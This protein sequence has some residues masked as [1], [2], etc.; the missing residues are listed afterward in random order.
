MLLICFVFPVLASAQCPDRDSLNKR[1]NFYSTD[2]L[3]VGT[4]AQFKELKQYEKQLENCVLRGDSTHALLLQRIGILYAKQAKCLQA[5]TYLHLSN[6]LVKDNIRKRSVNPDFFIKNYYNL[7]RIYDS[8]G[9]S[10]ESTAALDSCITVYNNLKTKLQR[11]TYV[12]Y[13]L[14][15]MELKTED[16]YNVGDYNK[17][18]NYASKGEKY[19]ADY[20]NNRADS[21]HYFTTFLSWKFNALLITQKYTQAEALLQNKADACKKYGSLQSLGSIYDFLGQVEI[22][23]NNSLKAKNYFMQSIKY[24]WNFND[25]IGCMQTYLNLG[26]HIYDRSYKNP[27]LALASY[28]QGLALFTGSSKSLQEGYRME[29]LNLLANMANIYVQYKQYD[30]ALY[31]YQLAFDQITP[32]LQAENVPDIPLERVTK[33]EYLTSLLLDQ[34]DAYYKLYRESKNKAAVEKAINLYRTTDKLLDRIKNEQ[35]DVA[36]KLFWRR[37]NHRLYEHAIEACY[38]IGGKAGEAFY[39]FEKSRAALLNDQLTEQQFLG[40]QDMFLQAQLQ[41]KIFKLQQQLKTSIVSLERS[42]RM[43]DEL[44]QYKEKLDRFIQHNKKGN[45]Y[46]FQSFFD[47][48]SITIANVQKTILKDHKALVELFEGDSAVYVLAITRKSAWLKRINKADYDS[49]LQHYFNYVSD[50]SLSNR[51]TAA[52]YNTALH[53]YKLLFPDQALPAGRI[54]VSPDGRYIPFE[55]LITSTSKKPV[56]FVNDYAVSYTYSAR[57]LLILNKYKR[58]QGAGTQT[59]LGIAP[60]TY[61]YDKVLTDLQQSDQSV[62]TVQTYFMDAD[63]FTYG[64]ATKEKFLKN[65]PKY[66]IVYLSTHASDSGSTGEPVIYFA[67]GP[68]SLSEFVV[69]E[70]PATQLV[71][72]SACKTGLGQVFRGEGVY[73]FSRSF[74]SVGIPASVNNLWSVQESAANELTELFCRYIADGE[75]TDV[76]L[77]MAKKKMIQAGKNGRDLPYYW[78]A[79]IL[80][81]TTDVIVPKTSR[82]NMTVMLS[83]LALLLTG[84]TLLAS[85]V[86]RV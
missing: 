11:R 34:A 80:S 57:Y 58:K 15:M 72:A 55:A 14:R 19:I 52:H 66:K 24:A 37:D 12:R 81:G 25:T 17:C 1:L 63:I 78:A 40:D 4:P 76:A 77:Q 85:R 68:L 42:N 32:G 20:D 51:N 9:K 39:F 13:V 48:A 46:R 7:F 8:L 50:Y 49:T 74:A 29:A 82:W 22:Y 62:R 18:S 28:R 33:I 71:I 21:M 75:P 70:R 3:A 43:Q 61:K 44:D 31:Y 65:A 35:Q 41:S 73:N 10:N 54:I 36:S 45:N 64:E 47:S 86:V 27:R 84:G 67:D 2:I 59:L 38:Q 53:L 79:S 26:Y 6:Q 23:K 5:V 56:Y 60:V 16:F 83:L 30:S 69:E